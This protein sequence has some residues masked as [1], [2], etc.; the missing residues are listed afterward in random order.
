MRPRNLQAEALTTMCRHA[1]EGKLKIE[2]EVLPL[3]RVG[4]AWLTQQQS[5]GRKLALAP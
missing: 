1:A 4:E 5:P 2:V 3:E